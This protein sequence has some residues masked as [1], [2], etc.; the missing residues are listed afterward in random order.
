MAIGDIYA[1][2]IVQEYQSSVMLNVLHYETTVQ[3]SGDVASLASEIVSNVIPALKALQTNELEH[4][5]V[6]AQKIWP[7]P[8]NLAHATSTGA[9]VGGIATAGSPA[10]VAA[11]ITKETALAG[12]AF[13]GRFFITGI[14]Q[15]RTVGGKVTSTMLTAMDTLALAL[16]GSQVLNGSTWIPVVYHRTAHTTTPV[17]NMRSRDIVRAQRRRQFGK[18]S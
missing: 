14:P 17:I 2:Q 16:Q 3:G 5:F 12:R 13:R 15:S 7:L 4:T 8:V 6:V 18:G 10:E 9:G 1:I 11:V